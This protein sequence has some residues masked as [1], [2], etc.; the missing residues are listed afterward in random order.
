MFQIKYLIRLLTTF[1]Y[2][3]NFASAHQVDNWQ[4]QIQKQINQ[5]RIRYQLPGLSVSIKIPSEDDIKN[6]TTG[7][8]SLDGKKKITPS[9]LFQIGSITKTFTSTIIFQLIEHHKLALND[10]VGTW[11]L[12]YPRWRNI[13]IA[14]LLY[15]TSGVANYTHGRSFDKMMR[16]YPNKYFSLD[17]LASIAYKKPDL[18][19]PGKQYNYTNTDYILLGM[20]IEKITHQSLQ[21]VFDDYLHR[22]Q[23]GNTF[24]TPKDY[25]V[26]IKN[27]L[28]HGYNRDGTFNYNK[29][30]RYTSLSFGQSAGAMIATPNDLAKWLALLFSGKIISQAS[31][32]RLTHIITDKNKAIDLDQLNIKKLAA[33]DKEFTEVG[34][35]AGIGFIYFRGFGPAW[36]HAGGSLGHESLYIYNPCNGIYIIIL[37]NLKPKEQLIYIKIAQNIFKILHRSKEINEQIKTYQQQHSLPA[38]CR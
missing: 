23:L 14:D 32:D 29:D 20:I 33:S 35:G 13:T 37:Y 21:H 12:Q 26:P 11:L 17:E 27:R 36:V 3:L 18:A 25:P 24:Y 38:Y 15:H 30:I 31:L 34:F 10:K 22:Y 4:Q 28:A 5:D 16:K 9:T 19:K 7:Y 1:L 6:F 2:C 8:D